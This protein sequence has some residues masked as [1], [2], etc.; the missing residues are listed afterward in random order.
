MA[1]P[2]LELSKLGVACGS[3]RRW[4]ASYAKGSTNEGISNCA[5]A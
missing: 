4:A 3:I 2:D 1:V 5:A